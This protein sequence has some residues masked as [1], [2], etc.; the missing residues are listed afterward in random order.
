MALYGL[1]GYPL[2]HSF[3]KEYFTK[4]F[5]KEGLTQ[6]RFENFSI[7]NIEELNEVMRSHNDLKGL[8]VTIPHKQSVLSLLTTLDVTASAVGACNCIKIE[9]KNLRGYNTDVEGFKKSLEPLLG[10][11]HSR[12]LILGRGG[13]AKAVAYVLKQLSIEYLF[14]ERNSCK[15]EQSILYS[16]VSKETIAERKL[17]INTTPLGTFP[18]VETCPNIPYEALTREH[19]LFDL[20]YNPAKTLFLQKGEAMQAIIKN[21]YEML[22]LQAEESW[23]IW[24]EGGGELK[25]YN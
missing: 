25:N 14:V 9:G 16:H 4:K 21:G 18:D 19:L 3:S 2:T 22:V 5:N 11:Q 20:V 6:H 10:S 12:A 24:N 23:R 8:S 17:I 13:A 7:P 15:D 1:I